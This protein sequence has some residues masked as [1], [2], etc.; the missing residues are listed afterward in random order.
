MDKFWRVLLHEYSRHVFRRRFLFTLL[1]VP[2]ITAFIVGIVILGIFLTE[3]RRPFGYL[4]HSGLLSNPKPLPPSESWFDRPVKMISYR[5]ETDAKVSLT[6]G[7]IQAYYVLEE[8]YLI[9]L[10]TRL[11]FL[12]EPGSNVQS[13]FRQFVRINLLTNKSPQVVDR[14]VDG[15]TF[16]IQSLDSRQRMGEEEWYN[17]LVPFF[18]GFIFLIVIL[19]SGG[20]L[21][22]A[23]V[24]EKENRTMEIIVTSVS[25]DQL[26]AGKIIGNIAVGITQLLAWILFIVIAILMTRDSIEWVRHINLNLDYL[27]ILILVFLPSFVLVASMMAAIGATVTETREAQQISGLFSLP[28]SIPFYFTGPL[29]TNPNG[30]LA[31]GLSFFPLTAPSAIPLRA[32]FGVI[33]GWQLALNILLLVIVAAVSVWLASRAFRIGMLSYGKRLTLKQIFGKVR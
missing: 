17:I 20:Y 1:S 28:I 25:P 15:I 21:L 32:G 11:V 9:N 33:P 12:N 31:V 26:I 30:P 16:E 24:E 4:D 27:G 14:L 10:K 23:V 5:D 19:T 7:D 6:S 18:A 29:M 8:D 2:L 3:D 22:Q 13:Q